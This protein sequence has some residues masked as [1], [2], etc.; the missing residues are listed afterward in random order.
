MVPDSAQHPPFVV[1][2]MGARMHYA[3]PRI[4]HADKRLA[5]FYADI[6]AVRGWPAILPYVP[7]KLLP[8]GLRRLAARV[9]DGIPAKLITAFTSFGLEYSKRRVAAKSASETTAVHL[10]AGETFCDR[11][12]GA[13]P[14]AAT[15][16]YGYNSACLELLREWRSKGQ[17][18]VVEQTI[19]PRRIEDQILRAE[20]QNLPEWQI[21]PPAD[22]NVSAYVEREEAEWREADIIVCGSDFVKEGIANCGG[23]SDRCVVVP[24]GINLPIRPRI[25]RTQTAKLRALTVGEVSLRKGSHLIHEVA[26]RLSH[27]VEFRMAG[28][29]GLRPDAAERLK[30]S[31]EWVGIVPRNEIAR[32]Y[33]WADV[34]LLPSLCEGSATVTYEALAAGL[35][36]ITTL[37]S[38]SIVKDGLSGFIVPVGDVEAIVERLERF[39]ASPKLLQ[40]MTHAAAERSRFGTVEAYGERLLKAVTAGG[41]IASQCDPT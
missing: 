21:A 7:K 32:Q 39:M 11:V 34:F 8:E 27:R 17:L 24:Y 1:A 33:E 4:F 30:K 18:T 9:P 3:V 25:A 20:Q 22:E 26:S 2:L 41:P 23:P 36:V 14:P 35:P 15:S 19:A 10:W 28:T 12:L 37:N 13:S 31:V 16:L 5:R 40:D 29:M 38:G 6:C